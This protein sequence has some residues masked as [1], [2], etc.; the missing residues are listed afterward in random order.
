M[1]CNFLIWELV[2]KINQ[3]LWIM[4]MYEIDNYDSGKWKTFFLKIKSCII[5][6]SYMAKWKG[7]LNP[8]SFSCLRTNWETIIYSELTTWIGIVVTADWFIQSHPLLLMTL[9]KE[10]KTQTITWNNQGI[11]NYCSS[12]G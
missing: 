1:P 11:R 10:F 3:L 8:L 6:P 5:V 4:Y 7:F 9:L 12:G 2:F